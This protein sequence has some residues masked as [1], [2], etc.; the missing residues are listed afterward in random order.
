VALSAQ[1]HYEERLKN[2]KKWALEEGHKTASPLSS[3]IST[4]TAVCTQEAEKDMFSGESRT[5]KASSKVRHHSK[6]VSLLCLSLHSEDGPGKEERYPHCHPP[7][8][9]DQPYRNSPFIAINCSVIL[10]DIKVPKY[11]KTLGN[12]PPKSP[13]SFKKR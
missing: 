4:Q 11:Q 5:S 3:A 9:S 6:S 8:P 1:V 7:L 12:I 13:Y 10:P 2:N